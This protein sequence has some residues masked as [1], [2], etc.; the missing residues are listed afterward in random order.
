MTKKKKERFNMIQII[1][2]V[3]ITL[4][5][6]GG[7]IALENHW[8]NYLYHSESTKSIKQ[9]HDSDLVQLSKE[10]QQIQKNS[11]EKSAYDAVLFWNRLEADMLGVKARLGKSPSPDFDAKLKEAT[12]QKKA[13]ES[14][15]KQLQEVK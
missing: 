6:A 3:G 11:A 13:A 12:D 5:L 1:G 9:S 4:G 7:F 10:I 14:R 8:V 15:L 2:A